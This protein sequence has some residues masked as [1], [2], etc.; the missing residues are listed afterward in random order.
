MMV[1]YSPAM[2][3]DQRPLTVRIGTTPVLAMSTQEDIVEW[4]TYTE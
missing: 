3:T 4:K 2:A 1:R